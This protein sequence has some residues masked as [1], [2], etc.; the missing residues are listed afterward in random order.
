MPSSSG[1][2]IRGLT[3]ESL[4]ALLAHAGPG[5][6]EPSLR[7][8]A[9]AR[10]QELPVRASVRGG[11]GW[12]HDLAKLDLSN[13]TPFSVATDAEVDLESLSPA[14]RR[15]GVTIER[16]SR[17]REKHREAFDRAFGTA[18]DTRDDKFASLALA[19]QNHGT[20]IDVPAG[21]SIDEPIVV[22]YEARHEALFPYTLVSV[23]AGAR[24]TIVERYAS[25]AGDAFVCAATEIVL[26]ENAQLSY[27][28]EQRTSP[29]A[30]VIA[31]R[32]AKLAANA[33]LEIG[34]AELGAKHTVSRFRSLEASPGA[35]TGV[36]AG[37]F[38]DG[39]QHV[40]I[41]T[42]TVHAAGN[43]T[44]NTVVRSA[45]NG[46]GQGRYLGNIKILPEAHGADASLRDD[47][48]LLSATAHIDSVPA[49]E[50]AANDV[51]AF[52]GATVGAISDEEIFYAESRGIE[53]SQAERMIALGFF[54]PAVS[55]FPTETLRA[56]IRT[57][58]EAKIAPAEPLDV[59]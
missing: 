11:R 32:R 22:G 53:R 16:F 44:S 50:I 30:R 28:V 48:L 20:F 3:K 31:T 1:I 59:A 17:A 9:L 4:E 40:D 27:A 12:K 33:R 6:I 45:G 15:G 10:F 49:L 35:H 34:F 36:V 26:G 51:K 41:E 46:R 55:R 24:A 7:Y 29:A 43:T 42:E 58:L 8:D 57:A 19:F 18:L 5:S 39:D 14:A 56:E 37:F 23:G 54:E 52:H 2:A 38:S 47:A 13:V 25:I 21:T